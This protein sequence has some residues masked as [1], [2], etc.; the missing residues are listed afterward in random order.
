[1]FSQL[2]AFSIA[3]TVVG[4]RLLSTARAQDGIVTGVDFINP[5]LNGG[6]MLGNGELNL[7]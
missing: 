5:N 4:L 7:C 6:S 1:M 3:I 2:S